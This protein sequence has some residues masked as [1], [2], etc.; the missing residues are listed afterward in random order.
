MTVPATG[1]GISTVALSVITA[2]KSWSSST[3]CPTSTCHSTSSA[4]ATP[5]PTSGSLMMRTPMSGLHRGLEGTADAGGSGEIVPFLGVRIGRVPAGDAHHRR[6]E[7]VETILLHQ[8]T[9]LRAKARGQGRLVDD[10]AATGLL[11]RSDD[12]V[13]VVGQ[14]SAQI[15]DLG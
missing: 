9:E 2:A 7:M 3:D 10:D 14:Q 12:R 4:S 15:D 13:E 8:S 11:H 6:L 5:S 1:D